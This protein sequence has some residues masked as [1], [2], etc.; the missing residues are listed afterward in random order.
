[1]LT[2]LKLHVPVKGRPCKLDLEDQ[3]LLCLSYW[4]EYRTLFHVGMS[5]A[6]SEAIASRIVGHV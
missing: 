4:R 3:L 1:M 2:K 6:I 5:Y